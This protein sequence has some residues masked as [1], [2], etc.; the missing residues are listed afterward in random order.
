MNLIP[1]EVAVAQQYLFDGDPDPSF[2]L[3]TDA[4][5]RRQRMSLYRTVDYVNDASVSGIFFA[6]EGTDRPWAA[7]SEYASPCWTTDLDRL[8]VVR[9]D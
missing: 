6:A 2:P 9:A 1:A 3:R 7:S 8:P 4:E 5:S